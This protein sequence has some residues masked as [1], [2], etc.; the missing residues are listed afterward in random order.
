[1]TEILSQT[2]IDAL[3][4]A[5]SN[6]EGDTELDSDSSGYSKKLEAKKIKI[7]DFKRPD[8]FSKDQIRTLQMMHETFARISTTALS[9]QLR[10]IVDF[11]VATVDQ[12][13]YEEFIRSIPNPTTM[14]IINMDPL[15]GSII[16]EIDPTISFAIIDRLFGGKGEGVKITRELSDIEKT[17]MEGIIVKL[18][19]NMRESWATV[20]DLRPRLSNI[21]TNPQ[22]SQIVAP[23]DMSVLITFET[24]IGDIEG[25]TNICIPYITIEPI[26]GKLSAQYWYSSIRKDLTSEN[27]LMIQERLDSVD[28]PVIAEVDSLNMPIKDFIN[29][30]KGDIICSKKSIKENELNLKVGNRIKFKCVA[31]H[32]DKKIAVQLGQYVEDVPDD[33][34]SSTRQEVKY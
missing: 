16:I 25:V 22:F 17:V 18:L 4:N 14:S 21:E 3:L 8:K 12:L 28:V 19:G 24:K 30:D 27:T 26:V 5:I 7:Y 34:L 13:T 9:A 1:M 33:L 29:L 11:R 2:E 31:G 32:L 6:E 15:R 10:S 20:L 23:N